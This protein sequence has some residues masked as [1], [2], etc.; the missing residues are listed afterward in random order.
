[1]SKNRQLELFPELE[2]E[3]LLNEEQAASFL[4]VEVKTL[5]YWRWKGGGPKFIKLRRLVRYS[6]DS[7]KEFCEQNY[8]SNTCK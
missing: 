4:G 2:K 8:K 7:L 3:R 1:M 5:Q 6:P